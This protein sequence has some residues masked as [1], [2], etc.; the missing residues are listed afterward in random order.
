MVRQGTRDVA[1][2]R[3]GEPV[4]LRPDSLALF[5]GGYAFEVQLDEGRSHWRVERS[6]SVEESGAPRGK[7]FDRMLEALSYIADQREIDHL[8]TL[9]PED[10][11]AGWEAFWKRRDPT[12]DTPRNE[13]LLEF[14]RRVRYAETHFQGFGPG[15]RSDMGRIYIKFGPPD[16]VETRPVSNFEYATEIWYYGQPY[17]R[18]VFRDRDGFGRYVLEQPAAE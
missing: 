15:W 3:S 4:L 2:T 7:E 11:P 16:Q 9:P 14:L 8:R 6:F 17:R 13:A 18:F 12:P 5:I 1:L 10:Q